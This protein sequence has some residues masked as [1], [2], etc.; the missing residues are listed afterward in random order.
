MKFTRIIAKRFSSAGN[1]NSSTNYYQILGVAQNSSKEEIKK[2]YY[3]LA[4][5]YHPDSEANSSSSISKYLKFN[6]IF[7]MNFR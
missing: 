7:E 4:K 1:P 5:I 2:A 6:K 3:K